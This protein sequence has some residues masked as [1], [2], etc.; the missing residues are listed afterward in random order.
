MQLDPVSNP[1]GVTALCPPYADCSSPQQS[2]CPTLLGRLVLPAKLL[3]HPEQ[4]FFSLERRFLN[5][6]NRQN[7]Q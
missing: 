5:S 2:K 6:L 4:A 7:R 1:K 3:V